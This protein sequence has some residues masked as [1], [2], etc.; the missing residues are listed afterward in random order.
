MRWV[1]VKRWRESK[2][3]KKGT[4]NKKPRGV[5]SE[6]KKGSNTGM[7]TCS[8]SYRGGNVKKKGVLPP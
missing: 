4:G 8:V 2:R 7:S 3:E 1:K 6:V 5:L